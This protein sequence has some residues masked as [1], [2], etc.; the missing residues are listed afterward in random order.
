LLFSKGFIHTATTILQDYKILNSNQ[1]SQ[2]Q[3]T[4]QETGI[5]MATSNVLVCLVRD[6]S[7]IQ[8]HS[9]N[10]SV[11]HMPADV[12]SNKL[13]DASSYCE[14]LSSL[15]GKEIPLLSRN[16]MV[17]KSQPFNPIHT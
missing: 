14:V 13:H 7:N 8:L 6:I 10:N 11:F 1:P 17:Q 16:T 4:A 2:Y 12:C 9:C 15:H 5:L 3:S